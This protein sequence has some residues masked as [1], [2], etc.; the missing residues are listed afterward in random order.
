MIIGGSSRAAVKSA[1]VPVAHAAAAGGQ[2]VYK[3]RFLAT[4]V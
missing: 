1:A 2:T 4:T 3:R